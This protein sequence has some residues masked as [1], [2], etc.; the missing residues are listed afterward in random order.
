M[1]APFN[2]GKLYFVRTVTFYYLATFVKSKR[3]FYEF[4]NAE[5]ILS[6]PDWEDFLKSRPRL[7]PAYKPLPVGT[8]IINHEAVVDVMP[9][10]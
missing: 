2:K 3:G 4:K 7:P 9:W 1:F 8:I 6:I 5:C 10:D